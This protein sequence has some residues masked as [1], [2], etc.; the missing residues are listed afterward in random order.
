MREG[1]AGVGVIGRLAIGRP[2]RVLLAAT[3][4]FAAAAVFGLPANRVL[5][6]GSS[7]FQASGSQ[8]ARANALSR[9][10]SGQSAYYGV[11]VLLQG[12]RDIATSATARRAVVQVGLLL[13]R[14]RGFQRLAD[15]AST[16]SRDFVSRDGRQTVLLAAY[17][18]PSE[19]VAAVDRLRRLL[20]S[21]VDGLHAVFGGPDVAFGELDRR[22][23]ADLEHANL[24]ALAALLLL[25]PL[26]FRG[27]VA[28]VLPLLVGGMAVLLAFA[29]LRFLDQVSGPEISVYALP[30]A[31]G[32]GLG[33]G[34]DYSR[35]LLGRYREQLATGAAT[36]QALTVMLATAGRT[37]LFSSLT[38]AAAAAGALLV[39]PLQFLGS[40][41]IAAAL[42][43][44]SAGAAALLLLPAALMLLGPRIDAL[45]PTR[46]TWLRAPSERGPAGQIR[47]ALSWGRL[48]SVVARRPLPVAAVAVIVLLAAAAPVGGLRL[49]PPSARLLPAGAQS[50]QVE[51]ALANNFD[52][53]PSS[54]IYTIYRVRPGGP[55]VRQLAAGQAQVAA[56][57]AQQLPARY[58]G[59]QTWE[60]GLL[61]TGSPYTHPN[62][63]LL[64]QLRADAHRTGALVSGLTAY[65]ADQRTSIAARLP[66]AVLILLLVTVA[67]VFLLTGAVVIAIKAFLMNLLTVTA[68][69]GLL[70]AIFQ[71]ALNTAGVEEANLIFLV[72]IAFALATDYE[73]FLISRIT[74]EHHHGLNNKQAV[75]A[76]L[77]RTG[78]TIT[79]AAL[80]FCTALA[81]FTTAKLT[82]IQQFGAGAAL[83][84]L[85]DATIVRALLVPSLMVILDQA[86]W[87][88]PA[89]LQAAHSR[90]HRWHS[91]PKDSSHVLPSTMHICRTQDAC[92]AGQSTGISSGL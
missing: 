62:Q 49:I 18:S 6:G 88:A 54:V 63:Q 92:D 59:K 31:S 58:L 38:I 17:A 65:A 47:G 68:G 66:L 20:I 71:N 84:V 69:I 79:S 40:L 86:N 37:V 29:G 45:A 34:L 91:G 61:P 36:S 11:A 16:G 5:A 3:V 52:A 19:S 77:A 23:Q 85:I 78:P 60:L 15:L 9:W 4:V 56:G 72:A 24:V 80:L 57:R 30:A 82:F 10:A 64:A 28:A 67:A 50:R 74:E 48:A 7:E 41:G 43:A 42:T 32:L 89:P 87:W 51:H 53:N 13:S 25:T 73:L 39:F 70:V 26:V 8:Y 81:A 90:V 33:L 1:W 14:Q 12:Q 35:L 83:M 21:R 44:L 75:A 27:L 46:P 76:G 55:T 2:G 22:T